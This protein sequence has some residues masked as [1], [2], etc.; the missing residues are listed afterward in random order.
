MDIHHRE[1]IP[2]LGERNLKVY[3]ND[4]SRDIV[5]ESDG[6]EISVVKGKEEL[7]VSGSEMYNDGSSFSQNDN[8]SNQSSNDTAGDIDNDL[9]CYH[10]KETV[11]IMEITNNKI[12]LKEK[13]ILF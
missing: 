11:K 3:S 9:A 10:F 7:G 6:I 4:L 13:N 5:I 8:D 12:V 1:T 2:K